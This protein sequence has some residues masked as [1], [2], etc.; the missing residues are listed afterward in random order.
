MA[1]TAYPRNRKYEAGLDEA[2][3]YLVV[4]PA[5]SHSGKEE[6]LTSTLLY[7]F[8]PL[9]RYLLSRIYISA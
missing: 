1:S 8:K 5:T 7:P 2:G 4:Y 9:I 6:T 3:A